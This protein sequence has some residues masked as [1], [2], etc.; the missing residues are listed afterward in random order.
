MHSYE[1]HCH[2]S[3]SSKC[4][5]C[6]AVD[7]VRVYKELGYSG[8]F[9]TDHFFNGN[10]SVP[11]DLAWKDRVDAFCIGYENALSEGKRIGLDVFFGWEYCFGGTDFLTY[12]L[13]K[14]W[15]YDHPE[16]LE[17]S[18]KEYCALVHQSGGIIIH[19]HPFRESANAYSIEMI[20]LMPRDV[21]GVESFNA[22]MSD[23]QND[24]AATYARA[25]KLKE[26]AGTDN[27]RGTAKRYTSVNFDHRLK[28][29][30]DFITS[31]KSGDYWC[32]VVDG[33]EV[34]K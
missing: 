33:E 15:L 24:F 6:T 14:Q 1:I 31:F 10:T 19:A 26:V 3:E 8:I 34:S 30:H 12:G 23:F 11:S 5:K 28:D 2:T 13:D 29:E 17:L 7:M 20:R 4:G 18:V 22:N 25:Y 32:K 16:C 9:I 21:D 27:H